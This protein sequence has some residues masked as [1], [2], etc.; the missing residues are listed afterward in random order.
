MR[1]GFD[2]VLLRSWRL[3]SA[4]FDELEIL[5][6]NALKLDLDRSDFVRY[7]LKLIF[8]CLDEQVL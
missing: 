8:E 7:V 2:Q 3:I 6:F 4:C 1:I 5:A